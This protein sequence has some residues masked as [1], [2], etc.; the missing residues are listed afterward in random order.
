MFSETLSFR[1]EFREE[2]FILFLTKGDV[3]RGISSEDWLDTEISIT[4]RDS[5][6]S[7][8]FYI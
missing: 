4:F 7:L 1:V 8:V 5:S 2:F 3:I 6:L